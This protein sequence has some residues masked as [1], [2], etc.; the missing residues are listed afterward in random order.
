MPPL[1]KEFVFACMLKNTPIPMH[2]HRRR[3][4][5]KV[6]LECGILEESGMRMLGKTVGYNVLYPIQV[7]EHRVIS[8]NGWV[9]NDKAW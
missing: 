3:G 8:R 6:L 1:T 9:S 7:D 5:L 2:T 4:S